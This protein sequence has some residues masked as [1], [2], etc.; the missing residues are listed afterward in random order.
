MSTGG[1]AMWDREDSY[2]EDYLA[3]GKGIVYGVLF[4]TMLWG[5][6]IGSVVLW[7]S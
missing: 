7:L 3:V 1:T 6:I 2:P 5:I 4:G